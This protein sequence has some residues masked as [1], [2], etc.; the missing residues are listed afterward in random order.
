MQ[1]KKAGVKIR[2][3]HSHSTSMDRDFKW[4]LKQ[5]FR[6]KLP[7]VANCFCACSKMAGQYLFNDREVKIIYNAVDTE[8]F[9][10]DELVRKNKRKELNIDDKF[11]IGHVGRFT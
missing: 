1:Q 4:L 10:Y 11:V 8:R 9:E 2:I 6:K 5:Y 3:A 7:S